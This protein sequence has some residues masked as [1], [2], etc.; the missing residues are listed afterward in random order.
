LL[1][2]FFIERISG[3]DM[4][5]VCSLFAVLVAILIAAPATAQ[6]DVA[7]TGVTPLSNV[8]LTMGTYEPVRVLVKNHSS[9]MS[10][11]VKVKASIRTY[12]NILIFADSVFLP[13]LPANSTDT[14]ELADF[15][16]PES[17]YYAVSATA[18]ASNDLNDANNTFSNPRVGYQS[19]VAITAILSPLLDEAKLQKTS[20]TFKGRFKSTVLEA[21]EVDV[22]ARVQLRRCHDNML[23]FQ[24]DSYIPELPK[25]TVSVQF[26]FPSAQGIYDVRKLDPGCYKLA[27]MTRKTSDFNFKNDT[28]YSTF[29]IQPN[30]LLNDVMTD[31]VNAIKDKAI[32]P[33]EPLP[34]S[35]MFGNVGKLGQAMTQV[36]VVIRNESNGIAYTESAKLY[37][38]RI[39]ESRTQTFTPFST[40]QSGVYKLQAFTELAE[41]Q[42]RF[43]DTLTRTITVE[44]V[45]NFTIDSVLV[46]ATGGVFEVGSVITPK[47][48]ISWAGNGVPS[49]DI[50]AMMVLKSIVGTTEIPFVETLADFTS[51][52][53]SREVV[54]STPALGHTLAELIRGSY[55]ATVRIL[56]GEQTVAVS[57]P[58]NF[59]VAYQHD[60]K[61]ET[62]VSPAY[63]HS[64][65]LGPIAIENV[66]TNIGLV[67][68]DQAT[69]DATITDRHGV[70]VYHDVKDRSI[71]VLA[72]ES[73]TLRAFIP[74]G[75]GMYEARFQIDVPN[76]VLK[77]DNTILK[78]H[79][80]VGLIYDAAIDSAI[81]PRPN[82]IKGQGQNFFPSI[83]LDW[84]GMDTVDTDVALELRI[85]KCEDGSQ[86]YHQTLPAT[87]LTGP[88]QG[89]YT[90]SSTSLDGTEIKD[91]PHGCYNAI[92]TANHPLDL[93][94]RDDTLVVPFSIQGSSAAT[95][96]TAAL[97]S[98]DRLY[99]SGK[100]LKVGVTGEPIQPLQYAVYNILGVR[101]LA[102]TATLA[103][104]EFSIEMSKLSS[105]TYVLEIQKGQH[106]TRKS[107]N[108]TH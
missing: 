44:K 75:K 106:S 58:V 50:K 53:G 98:I 15:K 90:F 87:V 25:D 72:S 21:Q 65:P 60:V 81:N 20:F 91:L 11:Q 67:Y 55:K 28:L 93:D 2:L 27:M 52:F 63:Y 107:F 14:V 47:A 37:D 104:T 33:G 49:G 46:P 23:V 83:Y 80:H 6:V 62:P 8:R 41:D 105:G 64:Y 68:E 59:R 103:D 56:I 36:S 57:T 97:F 66:A 94:H 77:T 76:E 24:A 89:V 96:G 16:I 10:P 17:G 82:E 86:V 99:Q 18:S 19:D 101:I 12:T 7:V 85:L 79:F 84:L 3:K 54:F 74:P 51:A 9:V 13:G 40:Q 5:K 43:N 88:A 69:L 61:I 45:Y 34:L 35:F 92:F 100:D 39:G 95:P 4:N 48:A 73:F 108:Y 26:E 22:R 102:G 1:S 38:W 31:S 70:S 78:H 71:D 32:K 29:S 42:Y 30:T